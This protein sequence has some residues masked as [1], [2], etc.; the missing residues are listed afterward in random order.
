[1][2]SLFPDQ[3]GDSLTDPAPADATGLFLDLHS[4]G[5]L[6]LWP[7]GFT[8]DPAPNAS[9]LQTLGRKL[10]LTNRYRPQQSYSLYP[11]DGTTGS[12]AYGELGLAAYTIELGTWFF[13][14]CSSFEQSIVP[15]NLPALVYAA[16]AAR[17][18][19]RTPAG[20]DLLDL[21][22]SSSSGP[23]GRSF[24]LTATVD[25]TRY[26]QANGHEPAQPIA[27]AEFYVD[28]PPW[29]TSAAPVAHP[30]AATDG[31]FDQEAESVEALLDASSLDVGRHILFVRGKDADGNWGAFTAIFLDVDSPG[32]TVL[33]LPITLR[34]P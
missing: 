27:A 30:M 7:W 4:Y 22:L 9:A 34:T 23:A 24:H 3:R 5:Q 8:S 12:F 29:S 28:I 1:V 21:S 19:Y 25:D 10:A 26:S 14:D 15:D 20:P 33:Y 32:Y 16:K 17:T 18:P 11:A 2:R 13:Q 31:G 6:I